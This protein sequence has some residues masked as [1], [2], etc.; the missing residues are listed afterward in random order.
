MNS[1][2]FLF[3]LFGA[4]AQMCMAEIHDPLNIFCGPVSCYDVLGLNRTDDIKQIKKA[5]RKISLTEHPDKNRAENATEVYRVITK[6]YEV[7]SGNESKPLFDYYL[8][9]PR[10]YFKVSGQHYMR[11]MPKSDVRVVILVVLLLVSW[12]F[13]TIQYQKYEKAIKFLK[14]A[15]LNNLN[16]KNGG[17]KQTM[18]LFRRATELYDQEI[19]QKKASGDKS[20]GKIKMLKDPFFQTVVDKIVMEVKI[21]GG[22]RKPEWKDL[23][24]VQTAMLPYTL[25]QYARTYHRRYVSTQPL[26]L[27]DRTEMARNRVGLASWEELEPSEQAKLIEKKIW[28]S[29][30]HSAWVEERVAEET[31]RLQ[32][33]RGKGGGGS[34]DN[35]RRRKGGAA[36][37]DSDDDEYIE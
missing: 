29:E 27:E 26:S 23:V 14:F 1:V 9:H 28:L 32:K 37:R 22:Y 35:L 6:A 30:V 36:A 31:K 19:A 20:A 4:L 25:F 2:F 11:N 15:T 10:D 21:E 5:Y 13:H 8:D 7:L 12:F 18:E 34:R 3:F 17:T 24:I 16:L 33:L